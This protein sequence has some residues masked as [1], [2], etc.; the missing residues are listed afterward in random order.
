MSVSAD[1][2]PKECLELRDGIFFYRKLSRRGG[3]LVLA[4][5]KFEVFH[6]EVTKYTKSKCGEKIRPSC[7]SCLRGEKWIG[8]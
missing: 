1:I 2:S 5:P 3:G 4:A 8:S 7:A 6:H